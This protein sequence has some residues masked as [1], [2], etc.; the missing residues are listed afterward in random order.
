MMAK[1]HKILI[2]ATIAYPKDR[3][4]LSAERPSQD[5]SR[6]KTGAGDIPSNSWLR[7]GGKAGEA[8]P[9]FNPSRTIRNPATEGAGGRK[10]TRGLNERGR[11]SRLRRV[12]AVDGRA[13]A[14]SAADPQ[15]IALLPSE[16]AEKATKHLRELLVARMIALE[17]LAKLLAKKAKE[18]VGI[19]EH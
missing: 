4:T 6:I 11:P 9:S 16:E 2:A 8:G 12:L 15:N 5:R 13:L 3:K 14:K 10:K 19:Y 7:G 18:R 1:P 17:Q